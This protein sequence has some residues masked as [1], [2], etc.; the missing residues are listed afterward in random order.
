MKVG[1]W[2]FK[3][4]NSR[5]TIREAQIAHCDAEASLTREVT[6]VAVVW[7]SRKTISA[8]VRTTQPRAELAREFLDVPFNLALSTK[9]QK[10]FSL[11]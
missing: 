5:Q 4:E 9:I 11:L 10:H 6:M 2:C 3:E 1:W 7:A 8:T